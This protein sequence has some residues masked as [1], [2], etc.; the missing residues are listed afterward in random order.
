MFIFYLTIFI[1]CFFVKTYAYLTEFEKCI[2]N[3]NENNQKVN[4]FFLFQCYEQFHKKKFQKNLVYICET[5]E[6]GGIGDR[7]KGMQSVFY[8]SI[9][10]ERNYI[11]SFK[12]NLDISNLFGTKRID[13]TRNQEIKCDRNLS[14]MNHMFD[15]PKQISENENIDDKTI[16][17]RTNIDFVSQF[18]LNEKLKKKLLILGMY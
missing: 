1:Y 17:M 2:Q 3:E 16:C 15:W 8:T 12:K 14:L 13:W 10:L 11:I 5:E 9:I 4:L 6:C 7:M 18:F